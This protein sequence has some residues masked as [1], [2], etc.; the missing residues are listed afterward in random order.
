MQQLKKDAIVPH[1]PTAAN[2]LGR[3]VVFISLGTIA[4]LNMQPWLGI[5][6]DLTRQINT[7]PLLD[8]LLTVPYLGDLLAWVVPWFWQVLG[9]LLWAFVQAAQCGPALLDMIGCKDPWWVAQL[10]KWSRPNTRAIA[11]LLEIGLAFWRFPPYVGGVAAAQRDFPD[12]DI[13]QFDWSNALWAIVVIFSVE[14]F[15][16]QFVNPTSGTKKLKFYG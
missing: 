13:A 15:V 4:V 3:L 6:R 7:V 9:V 1:R 11:Y 10:G 14:L 12:L 5:A 2:K 16:F 8:V